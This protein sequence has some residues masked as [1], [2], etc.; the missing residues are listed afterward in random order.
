MIA[1]LEFVA[2]FGLGLL[3]IAIEGIDQQMTMYC[4]QQA[5]RQVDQLRA[6]ADARVWETYSR[7]ELAMSP[8]MRAAYRQ[9][10]GL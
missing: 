7:W 4:A 2:G 6:E 8:Q 3:L 5:Q 1:I 9:R 10:L